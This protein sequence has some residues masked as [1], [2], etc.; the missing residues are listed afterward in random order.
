MSGVAAL[1]TMMPALDRAAGCRTAPRSDLMTSWC[2]RL[3]L[4]GT[5]WIRIDMSSSYVL[6]GL[7]ILFGIYET[8]ELPLSV[9]AEKAL[10]PGHVPG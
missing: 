5:V 10:V 4:F 8:P 1:L 3:M 6:S 2:T 7:Q 9:A